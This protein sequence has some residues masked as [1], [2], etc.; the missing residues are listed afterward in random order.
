MRV[1]GV[2][3][4]PAFWLQVCSCSLLLGRFPHLI[5]AQITLFP[6]EC[7]AASGLVAAP[8]VQQPAFPF[9]HCHPHRA[10]PTHYGECICTGP[11]LR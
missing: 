11:C 10:R 8:L 3:I 1:Y 4:R 5:T 6:L 2:R 9:C 7:N